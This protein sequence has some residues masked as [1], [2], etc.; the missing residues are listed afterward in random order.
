MP[1]GEFICPK[2]RQ[3]CTK[4]FCTLVETTFVE[5]P[6][7]KEELL[8][9]FGQVVGGVLA[10]TSCTQLREEGLNAIVSDGS[11]SAH[12]A[13]QDALDQMEIAEALSG[14]E[15]PEPPPYSFSLN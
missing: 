12:K 2:S 13:A 9:A 14:R 11:S 5:D 1:G 10:A 3:P 4:A 6:A 8:E 15:S 7:Y